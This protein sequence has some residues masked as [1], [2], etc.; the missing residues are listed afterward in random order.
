MSLK[1]HEVWVTSLLGWCGDPDP[2]LL[3]WALGQAGGLLGCIPLGSSLPAH[4]RGNKEQDPFTAALGMLWFSSAPAHAKTKKPLT[5]SVHWWN[6][7]ESWQSVRNYYN[8][9]II[10]TSQKEDPELCRGA[11]GEWRQR[12]HRDA[13]LGLMMGWEPACPAVLQAVEAQRRHFLC[14]YF[15][16]NKAPQ[17]LLIFKLSARLQ[18]LCFTAPSH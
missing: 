14:M 12:V 1:A 8:F 4:E 18:Y 5:P 3:S 15:L 6:N 11:D 7:S 9:K 17:S 16:G 13:D 10:T 2:V